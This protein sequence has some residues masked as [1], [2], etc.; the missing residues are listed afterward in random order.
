MTSVVVRPAHD[1]DETDRLIIRELRQRIEAALARLND[2]Q[3][4]VD[5]ATLREVVHEQVQAYQRWARED[6]RPRLVDAGRAEHELV[7]ERVGAGPLQHYLDDPNVQEVGVVGPE[8]T[9]LWLTDGSKHLV[10][11]FLFGSNEEIA[12]LVRR[13]IAPSGRRGRSSAQ[14]GN[15]RPST[16]G[17]TSA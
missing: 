10:K 17:R 6:N 8:R 2:G 9:Q 13:L 5:E 7:R 16:R 4:V 11:E 14:V 1:L 3:A 15:T 12:D